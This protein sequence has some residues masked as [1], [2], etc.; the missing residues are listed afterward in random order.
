MLRIFYLT[1]IFLFF[2]LLLSFQGLQAQQQSN[3]EEGQPNRNQILN[4]LK[5]KD[6]EKQAEKEGEKKEKDKEKEKE[7]EKDK[8]KV[9]EEERGIGKEKENDIPPYGLERLQYDL[10]YLATAPT[11]FDKRDIPRALLFIGTTAIL[12]AERKDI[13]ERVLENT[14]ETRKRLY[15][16]ARISGKG[17]FA[18]A[19]ALI[20]F[21]VG[22]AKNDDYHI[23]TSQIILESYAMSALAAGVGSFILSTERPRDGDEIN[24]FQ[25]G[26]HGVSLDVALASSFVFPI[27]D[28]YLKVYRTDSCAKKFTKYAVKVFLFSLPILTAL[29]RISSDSHWAPDVFLGAAAGLAIGKILSRAHESK[30]YGKVNIS[31]SGGMLRFQ[32]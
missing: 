20:F 12:Y 1:P 9:Q 19:M 18:P 3:N 30:K 15:D 23:E 16:Y 31:V 25:S 24:F 27:A 6:L 2:F 13:R 22:K 14:T 11:R 5:N 32:F 29:Q 4:L 7:K 28:R 8:E 17:A 26:G 21:T 10:R